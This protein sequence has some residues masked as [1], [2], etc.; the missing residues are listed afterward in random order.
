MSKPSHNFTAD[1]LCEIAE[2]LESPQRPQV[3]RWLRVLLLKGQ[4]QYTSEQIADIVG[5]HKDTVNTIIR[6]YDQ[7]GL[8][9]MLQQNRNR[10]Y[11][12]IE[13]EMELLAP[14]YKKKRRGKKVA[15][16]EV[17]RAVEE[18][19]GH[20]VAVSTVYRLM[21]RHNLTSRI[22]GQCPQKNNMNIMQS[23]LR[24]FDE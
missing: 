13:E 21:S 18:H 14:F 7:Y 17:T 23:S 2:A 16:E 12:T 6:K 24:F 3:H 10:S 1:E 11:M 22:S 15:V 20:K 8:S 4:S 19:L 9:K 5:L